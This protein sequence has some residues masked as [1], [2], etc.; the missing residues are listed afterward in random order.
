MPKF[1]AMAPTY[2]S[3]VPGPTDGSEPPARDPSNEDGMTPER[4][5][6]VIRRLG[7][8]FYEAAEVREEIARKIRKELDQ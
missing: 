2:E 3:D 4:V 7:S 5:Q 6:E 1:A 8:G